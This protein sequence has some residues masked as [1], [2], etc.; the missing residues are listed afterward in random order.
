MKKADFRKKAIHLCWDAEDAKLEQAQDDYDNP[1][2]D[3][4]KANKDL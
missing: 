3:A 2:Y 1:I 4:Y